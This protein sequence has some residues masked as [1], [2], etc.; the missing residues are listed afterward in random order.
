[1]SSILNEV[2]ISGNVG[3]KPECK[4]TENGVMIVFTVCVNEKY[5]KDGE[6]ILK[7]PV[8]INCVCYQPARVSYLKL[9][10]HEGSFIS[11]RGR[12]SVNSYSSNKYF[13]SDGKPAN[14]EKINLVVDDFLL[15][16]KKSPLIEAYSEEDLQ[17]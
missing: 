4:P 13:D 1:M 17:I 16:P 10:L 7:K 12:L 14:I 3:R 8:W 2:R 5:K 15:F 11:L 6:T 9:H